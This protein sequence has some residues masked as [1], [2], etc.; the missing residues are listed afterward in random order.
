MSDSDALKRPEWIDEAAIRISS[1]RDTGHVLKWKDIA[2]AI[3]A[4]FDAH[5]ATLPVAE[6]CGHA[7]LLREAREWVEVCRNML[8]HGS[9]DRRA[10]QECLE[11]IDK[12]IE[13]EQ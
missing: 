8:R 13:A 3:E 11:Q 7:R 10:A 6:P 2:D 4:A 12:A 1:L 9:E 5:L